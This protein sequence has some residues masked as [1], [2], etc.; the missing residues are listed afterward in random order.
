V[1]YS[2]EVFNKIKAD[3]INFANKLGIK[4]AYFIPVSAKLGDNIVNRSDNM[5][6][7]TGNTLMQ[8]LET[9]PVDH[10]INAEELRLPVQY[11]VRPIS[12]SFHDFRG[13]AGRLAG[14]RVRV[15]EDIIVLPSGLKSKVT[16]IHQSQQTVDEAFA[17]QSVCLELADDID[18]SRGDVIATESG[19][20]AQISQDLTLMVC[21]FN[22]EPL[23]LRKRYVIRQATFET[24]GSVKQI[25][26]RVNINTLEHETDVNSLSANDIAEIT[27]RTASPL[28][29]DSYRHNRSTGSLIFVDPDTNETVGAGMII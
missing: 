21:W 6:W 12:D 4:N 5:P 11:V 28:V 25:N 27:I 14:G 8:L 26:Y 13:Y 1:D 20:P 3:Y 24:Q 9:V 18:I 2:E 19:V 17:P 16:A 7:Y 29:F 22:F 23:Q 15:G 10:K